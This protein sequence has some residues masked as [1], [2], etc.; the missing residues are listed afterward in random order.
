MAIKGYFT[1]AKAP[2]LTKP[3]YHIVLCHIQ[4]THCWGILTLYRD[5]VDVF[6]NSNWLA[7]LLLGNKI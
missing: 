7:W 6:D 3:H 2:A 5:A 1:F 4:D